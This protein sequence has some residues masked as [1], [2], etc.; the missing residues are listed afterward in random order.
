VDAHLSS[1]KRRQVRLIQVKLAP[2][3]GGR[4]TKSC[5]PCRP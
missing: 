5:D 2:S 1:D 3:D 4:M